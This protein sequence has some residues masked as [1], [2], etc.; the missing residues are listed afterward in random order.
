MEWHIW[1]FCQN[2]SLPR[3]KGCER[4]RN[5]T[6]WV[7]H[8]WSWVMSTWN[9]LCSPLYF[10]IY[11]K[12]FTIKFF[13]KKKKRLVLMS[14]SMIQVKSL[15]GSALQS[16][17]SPVILPDCQELSTK[18]ESKNLVIFI[19]IWPSNFEHKDIFGFVFCVPF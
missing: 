11:L 14:L 1:D 4:R 3:G 16:V 9:S 15:Q 2:N 5:K 6:D 17:C 8:C 13:F 10:C 12:S 18:T 7:L 19:A